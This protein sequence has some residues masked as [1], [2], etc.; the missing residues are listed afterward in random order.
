MDSID[1]WYLK[2]V[3]VWRTA[4]SMT[5]YLLSLPVLT[6]GY[7][8]IAQLN[9]LHPLTWITDTFSA[10]LSVYFISTVG[11]IMAADGGL[12]W[13]SASAYSVVP[14]V[15]DIRLRKVAWLL[16]P[17]CLVHI[18]VYMA[19]GFVISCCSSIY[20]GDRFSGFVKYTEYEGDIVYLNECHVMFVM[21]GMY[22]GL[23]FCC[24]FH[25]YQLN[26]LQFPIIQREKFFQVRSEV[27]SM[28]IRCVTETL[29]QMKY[30]YL[31]YFL[32]GHIP[33]GWILHSLNLMLSPDAQPLDTVWGLLDVGVAIQLLLLGC[34]LNYTWSLSV[35]LYR[36]YHTERLE[37][38]VDSAFDSYKNKSL[39][40]AISCQNKALLQHLGYLDLLHLARFSPVRRRQVLTLSQPGGHP[41]TWNK[42]SAACLGDIDLLTT[43]VQESNWSAMA[44]VAHKPPCVSDAGKTT[45]PAYGGCRLTTNILCVAHQ[46]DHK[47]PESDKLQ[48]GRRQRWD[49]I[50]L[51]CVRSSP[52]SPPVSPI[53]LLSPSSCGVSPIR[54]VLGPVL[55]CGVSGAV[56]SSCPWSVLSS[57][58]CA[59]LSVSLLVSVSLWSVSPLFKLSRT[60]KMSPYPSDAPLRHQLHSAL[61]T[62]IY[63]IVNVFGT[64]L[65]DV[66]LSAE[67][68]KK[69]SPFIDF[70]E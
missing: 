63:R 6:V 36:V 2:E 54:C 65:M 1:I 23:Y 51:L 53:T 17:G 27:A 55:T 45:N 56:L 61:K 46:Y 33:R 57:S 14:N 34:F 70:R 3:Y 29:H 69:L 15:T 60:Q 9:P 39:L 7:A 19:A 42:L 47:S 22:T 64:H 21:Y 12:A 13:L 40:S 16:R 20:A 58:P 32:L 44:G 66:P 24:Q 62:S 30:F 67:C 48:Q 37:F 10:M 11:I 38:P 50:F 49:H 52:V 5:W 25:L 18:S 31:L 68:R 26:Y 41:H 35:L 28:F 8:L 4:A 43:Q 59:V